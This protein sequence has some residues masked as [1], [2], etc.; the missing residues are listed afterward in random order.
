VTV[1]GRGGLPQTGVDAVVLNVTAANATGSSFVTVWPAG[2]PRPDTSNLNVVSGLAVPNLVVAKVGDGG[3][4]SLYNDS[5]G[6]DLIVDLSGW[7]P[8][9]SSFASL[10]PARLLDTRAGATTIDGSGRP[11]LPVG[12]G[13]E[14]DLQVTGRGGVPSAGVAAV[15]LN[16]TATNATAPSFVTVWPAGAPRAPT[17]NLNVVVG[18]A[19][20]NLVVAKVGD[21]GRVALYNDAGAVDLIADVAGWFPADSDLTAL[22]PARL[23]D[24]RPGTTTVDGVGSPSTP[25]GPHGQLNVRVTGRAGIPSSGVAAVV[26]NVTATNATTQSFITVFPSGSGRPGTSNLNVIPDQAVPNLVIT[27]VGPDGNVTLYNE[28]GAVDLIADVAGWFP[29]APTTPLAVD[30]GRYHTCSLRADGT[31]VCWGNS[32][33]GMAG[34]GPVP[35]YV[36][37]RVVDAIALSVGDAHACVLRLGGSVACWSFNDISAYM[38]NPQ[39]IAIAT[40]VAGITDAVAIG[41]GTQNCAVLRTGSVMCWGLD[42]AVYHDVPYVIGGIIDAVDIAVG[43]EESCAVRANGHVA[44]WGRNTSG[45]GG[46]GTADPS[47]AAVAV[48]GLTDATEVAVGTHSA[49][50]RR[51]NSEAMCWGLNGT[52]ELGSGDQSPSLVPVPVVVLATGGG[53]APFDHVVAIVQ[54]DYHAC[55]LRDSG[56]VYCWGSD[57]RGQLG[58]GGP[59]GAGGFSTVPVPTLATDVVAVGSGWDQICA[60]RTGG[61]VWCWGGNSSGQVGDGTTADRSTPAEVHGLS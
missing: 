35:P 48:V 4:V 50:A 11:G 21:G 54:G 10:V 52:G 61:H 8:S 41:S 60:I 19:V 26:M 13:G 6:V 17:S 34:Y 40:D 42:N 45:E 31:V 14:L 1:T 2:A 25:V 38:F 16:V 43:Y 57:Y 58:Q 15:V 12:N 7:F 9:G 44:C 49:C 46:N 5:G 56:A 28:A 37:P 47:G 22:T 55:A 24:T 27:K 30:G 18:R 32:I 33:A 20:P 51:A 39:D 36:V 3:R 53:F 29:V 23:L 59:V